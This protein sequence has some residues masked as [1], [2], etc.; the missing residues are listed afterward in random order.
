MCTLK[1]D[2][3]VFRAVKKYLKK[4]STKEEE[5]IGFIMATWKRLI[6]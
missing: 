1:K 5:D 3:T 4:D 6:F 2:Y